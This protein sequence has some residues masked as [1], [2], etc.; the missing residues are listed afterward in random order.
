MRN[1]LSKLR[2]F[3]LLGAT[4]LLFGLMGCYPNNE[5]TTSELDIVAT[6]YDDEYFGRVSPSSYHMPDTIAVIG[7]GDVQ[8][9]REEMDFILARIRKNFSD[10][11]WEEKTM[12]DENDLP[13]VVVTVSSVV[14]KVTGTGCV[15]WYPGWGW[16]PWYPGWGWG[17]GYCYP[18]YL[19]SYTTGTLAIDM[20]SPEESMDE[21][22]KRVW[23][24]GVNG[25]VRSSQVSNEE[26]VNSTIDKA[27]EQSPY[28]KP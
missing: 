24:A 12:I 27:F 11:G 21:T 28:L 4:V 18:T 2:T 19:Y 6:N 9:E 23:N 13:D 10:L 20:I 8:L 25:L 15:P 1:N 7:D 5:L 14:V 26:F 3:T 16:Y 17:G 22:F